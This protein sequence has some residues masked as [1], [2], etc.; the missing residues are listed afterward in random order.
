MYLRYLFITFAMPLVNSV[1][2]S[3]IKQSASVQ[4][5][6]KSH[7]YNYKRFAAKAEAE[8]EKQKW[9]A[10]AK[11]VKQEDKGVSY[12]RAIAYF[13]SNPGTYSLTARPY[14]RSHTLRTITLEKF[15]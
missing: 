9:I 6:I 1:K 13:R 8:A 7:L 11:K 10:A 4:A 3:F 14:A 12:D 15:K 5:K 2:D